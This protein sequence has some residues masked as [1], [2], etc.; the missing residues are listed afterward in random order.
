MHG[1]IVN[2]ITGYRYDNTM[3][4]DPIEQHVRLNDI[5]EHLMQLA[6]LYVYQLREIY[7]GYNRKEE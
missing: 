4:L 6:L 5:S 3:K 1:Q 7:E 2:E